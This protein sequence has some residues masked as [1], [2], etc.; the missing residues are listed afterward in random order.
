VFPCCLMGSRVLPGIVSFSGW[1]TSFFVH[2]RAV[3]LRWSI[4]RLRRRIM[5]MNSPGAWPRRRARRPREG[6]V[7]RLDPHAAESEAA[8][9]SRAVNAPTHAATP[10]RNPKMRRSFMAHKSPAFQRLEP[11][12]DTVC[13]KAS[14]QSSRG[15]MLVNCFGLNQLQNRF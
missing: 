2:S 15:L 14:D 5:A 6:A 8:C 9:E 7:C 10:G 11:S 1:C 4:F 12:N 3:C 13:T